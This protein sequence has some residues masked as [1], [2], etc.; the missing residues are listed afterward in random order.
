MTAERILQADQPSVHVPRY[1][2]ELKDAAKFP[3][4]PGDP[5][6]Y[7]AAVKRWERSISRLGQ[8]AGRSVG[9]FTVRSA[10]QQLVK[11][12]RKAKPDQIDRVVNRWVADRAKYQARVVARHESVEAFR[13]QQVAGY[14]DKPWIHGITWTLSAAHSHRDVCDVL[15][16]QDLYGLGP[17]GYPLDRIPRRHTS[18]LCLYVS[19]NDADHLKREKAKITGER[20]PPKPWLSG[21]KEQPGDWLK[22]QSKADQVAIAGPTRAKLLEQGKQI[23][24]RDGSKFRKVHNLLGKPKPVRDMGPK[25]DA[26]KLVEADRL[27]QVQQFPQL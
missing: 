27:N 14:K 24:A 6:L 1:V 15:A 25:V 16:N 3:R 21:K 23:M 2:R 13:D 8:G 26:S 19:I 5:N 9:D 18:D 17:G 22:A 12:L 7:E 11:D 10:S 20:E 4:G